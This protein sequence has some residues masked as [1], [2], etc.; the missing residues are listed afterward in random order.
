MSFKFFLIVILLIMVTLIG[1]IKETFSQTTSFEKHYISTSFSEGTEVFAFDI[2]QDGHMDFLST[3]NGDG[4]KVAWWENNGY[5]E[6]IEHT[7]DDGLDRTRSVRA[8]DLNEDG[9]IDIVV[10]AWA[11]NTVRW[12]E[13]DGNENWTMHYVDDNFIGAH[14]IDIKDVN[15]DGRPD[16]LCSS[17]D[18][19]AADSEIAWWEN[20]MP[21]TNWT[22][23]VISTRFKQSPF[24]HGADIDGDDDMDILACGELNG[25]VYWWKNDGN[26]NWTENMISSSFSK[27]HTV[28][29]R[30][31]DLDGDM[32]VI[33]AACMSSK[34]AWWENDGSQ[35]F[36]YHSMGILAGALWFDA[37]DLDN[38]GD[39]DLYGGGQGANKLVWFENDGSTN[40]SRYDFDDTFTQAFSVVHADFDND[41]DTDLVAI[42][43]MSNQIS[44]FENK[45]INPNLYDK[46]ECVVYDQVYDRYI[47][48]NIGD[49]SL[50]ETDTSNNAS[51]WIHGYEIL[52]GMCI[53]D[54]ILYT[55][56]GDTL[57]GFHLAT[58]NE[59]MAMKIINYNNLDGMCTD[60]NGF[61]YVIDTWGRILKVDLEAETY[62]ELVSTGLPDW[63]QDC[64]YDPFNDRIVVAAYQ[65]SAPIV[66]VDP[67]TGEITTLTTN[68]VGR[69]DGITI[70][71]FGNFYFATHIGGGRVHKYPNDFSD[72]TTVALGMGE[73]TGLNYNQQNNILAVPSFN[74]HT[75]YFIPINPIGL[76][77][78]L[79]GDKI[80]FSI[81]PNP[82]SGKAS[83]RYQI[84]GTKNLKSELFDISGQKITDLFEQACASGAYNIDINLSAFPPGLYLVRL[85][86]EN[87]MAVRKLVVR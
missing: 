69:Y 29:A 68:S 18:M 26:Q 80:E 75:V 61:L 3:C 1:F 9:D 33:G 14:T 85:T 72:Y 21:D 31:I 54:G 22:K 28:F 2:N 60:G 57:F 34:I 11:G 35:N 42:G 39:R 10:A 84:S 19:S 73:P 12:Y 20:N 46:P 15:D 64:V 71:Q 67:E 40:F 59:I 48:A 6:F 13:N 70:D 51:Y 25:E 8:A 62:E 65:A 63:P 82:C 56:D 24:I 7:V 78:P 44:W 37:A 23:H 52:Y 32:D 30:D 74:H 49:G 17:F 79:A 45:L 41:N 66:S 5:H 83:L 81:Y 16:V 4:G 55:S 76:A 47:V 58:G 43:Y 53:A 38:D 50:V 87:G 86:S 77:E 36:T 27:A